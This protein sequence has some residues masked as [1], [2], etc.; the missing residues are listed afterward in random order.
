MRIEK[1]ER[2]AGSAR[3]C[4]FPTESAPPRS[5]GPKRSSCALSAPALVLFPGASASC[6]AC[7]PC[8]WRRG[9][10]REMSAHK[11]RRS[12]VLAPLCS[13][14]LP[15]SARGPGRPNPGMGRAPLDR[16]RRRPMEFR[17]CAPAG[18][19]GCGRRQSPDAA[20][21]PRIHVFFFATLS[22]IPPYLAANT[23]PAALTR[24]TPTLR[25]YSALC[26][27]TR[28]AAARAVDGVGAAAPAGGAA[29]WEED[30]DAGR[31][32]VVGGLAARRRG[33]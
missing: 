28:E 31:A 11:K 3:A 21:S 4:S 20:L 7:S 14:A 26:R 29:A 25:L 19:G 16:V 22:R 17:K 5:P 9:E 13:T 12:R 10:G 6:L 2:G 33:G 8:A 32:A 18:R 1:R 15:K 27:R 24:H 23:S 30:E